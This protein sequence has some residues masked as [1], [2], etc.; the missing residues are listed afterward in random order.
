ML[1]IPQFS[2]A[3]NNNDNF[4]KVALCDGIGNPIESLL[5]SISV[6]N[7][8]VH[9]EVINEQFHQDTEITTTLANNISAGD[10]SFDLTDTSGFIVGDYITLDNGNYEYLHPRITNV[11]TNTITIDRPID[12]SYN[13]GTT[14]IKTLINMNVE[15]MQATPQSFRV[16]PPNGSIYHITRILIEMTHRTAGDNGLF[17]NLNELDNGV[18][19]R[20]YDG[21]SG[22]YNSFTNW[23]TNNDLVTDMYDVTYA[24][25][26]GGNGDYGTN[27]I[28]RFTDAGAIVYLDGT[29]GDF[30]E[31]LIQDDLSELESFKIKAQGHKEV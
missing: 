24:P 2:F 6:H 21:A 25:R 1:A 14:V 20:R 28:G 17:G 10:Y 9:R 31:I 11:A 22:I 15:A 27:A 16:Y 12:Y 29:A 23:K 13:A 8:D 18:V 30:F 19:V 5:G 7:A 26:S 4:L 3:Q